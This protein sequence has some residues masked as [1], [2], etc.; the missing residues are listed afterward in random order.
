MTILILLCL[1]IPGGLLASFIFRKLV[2]HSGKCTHFFPER[3]VGCLTCDE[4]YWDSHAERIGELERR[5]ERL[6]GLVLP[7]EGEI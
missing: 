7:L 3:G 5:V 2:G 6:S 4:W 1:A